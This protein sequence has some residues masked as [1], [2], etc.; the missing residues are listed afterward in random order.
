MGNGINFCD[1]AK[2]AS[3]RLTP[4]I[5]GE[6]PLYHRS[7]N[8]PL[9][10]TTLWSTFQHI[11][12]GDFSWTVLGVPCPQNQWPAAAPLNPRSP[13]NW[14]PTSHPT[15]LVGRV[16]DPTKIDKTEKK[17][18][19]LI[20]TSLWEDLEPNQGTSAKTKTHLSTG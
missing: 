14:C 11:T 6:I 12:Q 9:D 4:H 2:R 7:G 15:F 18:G 10:S 17:I 20:Q 16:R 19:T 8:K 5:T 1:T 3:Q 13:S